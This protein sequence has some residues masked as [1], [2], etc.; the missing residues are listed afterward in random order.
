MFPCSPSWWTSGFEWSAWIGYTWW[1]NTICVEEPYLRIISWKLK[2]EKKKRKKTLGGVHSFIQIFS[3][4]FSMVFNFCS[5]MSAVSV[6]RHVGLI[7]PILYS[8]KKRKI[9]IFLT[10]ICN[11]TG[12]YRRLSVESGLHSP[13][14]VL[15]ST[16]VIKMTSWDIMKFKI[17]STAME[18]RWSPALVC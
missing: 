11:V 1:L 18:V 10:K 8:I 5:W 7:R 3:L 6:S 14:T 15:W 4:A 17:C 16:T 9:R 13:V 12:S 2:K